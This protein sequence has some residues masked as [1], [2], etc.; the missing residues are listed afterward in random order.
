MTTNLTE[1]LGD[2]EATLQGVADLLPQMSLL[3]ALNPGQRGVTYAMAKGYVLEITGRV[4]ARLINF[5]RLN[6]DA[7][8][9][10]R[11]GAKDLVHN[12]AASYAQ[13]ARFPE[14]AQPNTDGYATVLWNR[15]STGLDDLVKLCD[16]LL[17][18][19]ETDSDECA[20]NKAVPATSFPLPVIDD[21]TRW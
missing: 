1:A 20:L 18:D 4:Q 12:G 6:G 16:Q 13:A 7:Q 9:R 10:I 2:Y 11:K 3:E 5:H 21:C 14:Q 19:Q 17:A 8:G 15:F